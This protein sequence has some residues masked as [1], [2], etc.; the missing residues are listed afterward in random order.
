MDAL[1]D[2]LH[3]CG[4]LAQL[5]DDSPGRCFAAIQLK[6]LLAHIV[7]TYDVRF[8]EGKGMRERRFVAG[9]LLPGKA[10]LEFR[11]RA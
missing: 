7:L 10:D 3:T 4:L 1:S 11:Q 5:A 2:E 6:A 9:V 8:E